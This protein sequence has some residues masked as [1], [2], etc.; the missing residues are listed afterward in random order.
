MRKRFKFS[1]RLFL[2]LVI[3]ALAADPGWADAPD[4]C[5]LFSQDDAE[6]LMGLEATG[7][8]RTD[9]VSPAGKVCAYFFKKDGGGYE[10]RLRIA[11]DG[12]ISAEGIYE[13]AADVFIRQAQTRK[14]HDY[15]R[16]KYRELEWP[17][18]QAFWNGSSVWALKEDLLFIISVNAPLNGSF[19]SQEE[20]T[21]AKEEKSL[22]LSLAVL[23]TA[24]KRLN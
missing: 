14:K 18:V 4:P 10:A 19:S 12:E 1:V 24:L 21:A 6:A 13:S 5:G 15:A 11:S 16:S 20:P 9:A 23:E 3:I 17:E 7:S 8:R 2:L 22:N